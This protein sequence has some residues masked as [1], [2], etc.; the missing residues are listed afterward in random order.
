MVCDT[1]SKEQNGISH[2]CFHMEMH[3]RFLLLQNHQRTRFTALNKTEEDY[4]AYEEEREYYAELVAS[5]GQ[6]NG[7]SVRDEIDWVEWQARMGTVRRRMPRSLVR[8]KVQELYQAL[9][10]GKPHD[11]RKGYYSTH[12]Q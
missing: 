4:D 8:T 6:T 5:G 7:S 2:E 12:H 9:P 1:E 11:V 10:H 3:S